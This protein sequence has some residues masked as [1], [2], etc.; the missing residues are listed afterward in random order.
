MFYGLQLAVRFLLSRYSLTLHLAKNSE[1]S[2]VYLFLQ[3]APKQRP[4]DNRS[5]VYADATQPVP[6]TPAYRLGS[7]APKA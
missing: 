6:G 2:T 7:Q 5:Q 1:L 3:R 4:V